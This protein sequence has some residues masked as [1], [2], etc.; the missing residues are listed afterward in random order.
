MGFSPM[1]KRRRIKASARTKTEAKALLLKMRRDA[2]DGLPPEQRGYTVGEAVESWL[3]YGLTRRDENTRTNRRILAHKHVLPAL[4]ARRLTDLTAEDVDAW[5]ADRAKTLSTDSLNRLLSILRSSIRRAQARELVRRNVALL[6]EVPRG[7]G[8]RPSKSLTFHQAQ[9]LLAA[10]ENTPMNAYIVV[11]LLTG[12][13]TEELRALTWDHLDLDADPPTIM[14]WRSV[15]QGG[16]TKTPRSRRTL[17]L[18]DRCAGALRAHR[19]EQ[20]EAQLKAGSKWVQLGL[21]FCTQIG[22]AL[23]AANVRRSFR[24]VVA[25]AGLDPQLWTPRE[26]RHSFVSLLS[27]SGLPIED[28]SHL[29]GHAS[30]R[31]TELIYRKELR[32]T[33]TKGAR[34]MDAIFEGPVEDSGSR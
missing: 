11:S 24:R 28:I 7:T 9:A 21:V 17:E 22:T 29:V 5:L 33:L 8:G 25:A 4:G 32:P 6:C 1:G 30:T 16:D 20:A 27:S 26:L 13:R 34:A 14:V 10:A 2:V 18:P 19:R 31:V 12:A 23:D 3:R 15:R